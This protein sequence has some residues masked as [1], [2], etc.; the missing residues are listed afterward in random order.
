MP[1]LVPA[2]DRPAVVAH[3]ADDVEKRGVHLNTGAPGTK[4]I[5]PALTDAGSGGY[6]FRAAAR[7]TTRSPERR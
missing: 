1:R 7:E 2:T 5:L 3:L 6:V 4:I